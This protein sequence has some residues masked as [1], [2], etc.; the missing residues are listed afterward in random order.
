[1][2]LTTKCLLANPPQCS[3]PFSTNFCTPQP[4]LL[5]LEC[6]QY[7][8]SV[9]IGNWQKGQHKEKDKE[10]SADMIKWPSVSSSSSSNCILMAL[11]ETKSSTVNCQKIIYWSHSFS[12]TH[13]LNHPVS[14][15]QLCCPQWIRAIHQMQLKTLFIF[16]LS[17][18]SSN[19]DVIP[20]KQP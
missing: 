6:R 1:M 17:V 13:Y 19:I 8:S 11:V 20:M 18:P 7:N 12:F 9:K 2:H 3:E 15:Y 10:E 16:C 5:C 14:N 4:E